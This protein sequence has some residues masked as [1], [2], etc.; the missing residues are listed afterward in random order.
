M[1]VGFKENREYEKA[2][3]LV[4]MHDNTL[5]P[6]SHLRQ[7]YQGLTV[8][9][10]IVTL[11]LHRH[12]ENKAYENK[13]HHF[14]QTD[15]LHQET[16][17]AFIRELMRIKPYGLH[18]VQF[19][20]SNVQMHGCHEQAMLYFLKKD[21]KELLQT[22]ERPLNYMI[23]TFTGETMALCRKYIGFCFTIIIGELH[24][25]R[26]YDTSLKAAILMLLIH[27]GLHEDNDFFKSMTLRT[28]GMCNYMKG[29]YQ[30][31]IMA[32][33]ESIR[34]AQKLTPDE[35]ADLIKSFDE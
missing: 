3:K 11:H 31:A 4:L 19:N 15:S 27:E 9:G 8:W 35:G 13:L 14:L 5:E 25:E 20:L 34:F 26:K 2:Y 7:L 10:W 22:L 12:V 28:I 16:K 18:D 23:A 21:Y 24:N 33:H 6:P 32:S 30:T 1:V 29:N 17:V